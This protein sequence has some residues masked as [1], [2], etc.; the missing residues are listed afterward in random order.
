MVNT[1][2]EG[3]QCATNSNEKGKGLLRCSKWQEKLISIIPS[4]VVEMG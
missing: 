3:M 4:N 1:S 2:Y